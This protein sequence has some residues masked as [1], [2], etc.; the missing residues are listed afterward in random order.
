MLCATDPAVFPGL[1]WLAGLACAVAVML[2][3]WLRQL[4]TRDATS[5]DVGWAATVGL[6][7]A[8]YAAVGT[9]SALAR[10]MAAFPVLIWSARLSLHVFVDRVRGHQGE[11]GRY[12]ALRAH[13]GPRAAQ[14]FVWIYLV[15]AV[16]AAWFALPSLLLSAQDADRP[17]AI[18]GLGLALFAIGLLL[19]TASDRFLRLHRRDPN[20]R[21]TACRRGPWRY[22]RHPN[23][24]GEWLLWCGIGAVAYEAPFGHLA[25]LAPASMFVLIRFVSGVPW[26]ERQSLRSRGDDYRAYQ[27]ETNCF[28]PWWPRAAAPSRG[29]S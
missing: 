8:G 10:A 26:S 2:C 18:Q 28:F 21:G 3:L 20:A 24:F 7:A 4:Q 17:S 13:L 9:G 11:D 27:R 23:Y 19:E 22:S 6:L 14:R 12:A 1:P 5:V 15:Q 29:A 16:L 25:L